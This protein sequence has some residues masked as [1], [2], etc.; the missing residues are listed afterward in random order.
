MYIDE[1]DRFTLSLA[2]SRFDTSL[3][4]KG[5]LARHGRSIVVEAWDSSSIESPI[6]FWD[7]IRQGD[8]ESSITQTLEVLFAFA[9]SKPVFPASPTLKLIA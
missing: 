3:L 2:T 6:R 5:R 4:A 8:N 1:S 7:L 9:R